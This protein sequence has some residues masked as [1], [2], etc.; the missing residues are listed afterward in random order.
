MERQRTIEVRE[1]IVD[2][3]ATFIKIG[4]AI[5]I[6]PDIISPVQMEELQQLCDEVPVFTNEKAFEIFENDLG[7][8][9]TDVLTDISPQPIAS[10][11]IGQVY[12]AKLKSTGQ[13]VALKVQRPDILDTVS[14]DLC[15]LRKAAKLLV[16]L[17]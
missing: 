5:S 15:L 8:K 16:M 12:K 7:F 3:G 6:R 13:D 2:L 17:P 1:L 14:L 10:A 4:Q 11:S 9:A